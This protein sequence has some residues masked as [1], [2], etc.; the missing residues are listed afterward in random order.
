MASTG[1]ASDFALI[2]ARNIASWTELK[3]DLLNAFLGIQAP[4]SFAQCWKLQD[5]PPAG[6]FVTGVGDITLP[7]QEPKA[8]QLIERARQAPYGKGTE[9]IVDTSVR[10][11]WELDAT[12]FEFRHPGWPGFLKHICSVAAKGLGI[13]TDIH[14]EIYKM[15]I[16]E[17]GAMFKA[18]TEYVL[19][20]IRLNYL[21]QILQH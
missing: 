9:T 2:Y 14:A 10:N 8:R 7:L 5:P 12:Q 20:L 13:N 16:Y 1:T 19:P 4:G 15:L 3:E 6:L 17:K 18:H 11:T 21:T